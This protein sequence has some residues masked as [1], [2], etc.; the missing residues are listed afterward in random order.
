MIREAVAAGKPVSPGERA[1]IYSDGPASVIVDM[2]LTGDI[3]GVN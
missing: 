2:L 1:L 3:P